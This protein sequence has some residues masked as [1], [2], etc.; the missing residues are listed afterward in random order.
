MIFYFWFIVNQIGFNIFASFLIIILLLL[1]ASFSSLKV[2]IDDKQIRI[3]FG[4]GIFRKSFRLKE[5]ASVKT[6]KNHWYYGWGI[7]FWPGS[8]MWIYNVSGFDA[9]ELTFKNNRICRIG[10]DEPMKLE[11]ALLQLIDK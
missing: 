10:T 8:R 7:R 5:I 1:L 3:K 4:Y 2:T 9:V 11:A 6:V